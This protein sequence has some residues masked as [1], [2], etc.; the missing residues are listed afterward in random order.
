MSRRSIVAV[1]K[2]TS[3]DVEYLKKKL[4]RLISLLGGIDDIYNF[5]KAVLKINMCD[6]REPKTGAITHPKFL[7]AVLEIL[8]EIHPELKIYVVESDATR[9]LADLYIRWF[10]YLK[11]IQ[12]HNAEWI[13]LSK[14]PTIRKELR[15]K[16]FKSIDI[17][18]VFQDAFF[19]TL[20]KLKTNIL[21]T[22]TCCLKNQYGCCLLY[23]SPSPRDR[24]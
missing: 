11:V 23:T 13:N 19:I 24:G 14:C 7:E 20:P 22:I 3:Y 6:A 8:R 21:S 1:V 15:G 18:D 5:D 4:K 9:V 17:P 16:V 12:K 2:A 10:G